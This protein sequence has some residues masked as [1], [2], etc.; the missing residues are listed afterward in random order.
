MS[1]PAQAVQQLCRKQLIH[2]PLV[3]VQQPLLVQARVLRVQHLEQAVQVPVLEPALPQQRVARHLI[4][5]LKLTQQFHMLS[6]KQFHLNQAR[7]NTRLNMKFITKTLT[8]RLIM[9]P[10]VTF[11]N[12]PCLNKKLNLR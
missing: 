10:T 6:R 5:H 12:H 11:L 7:Q 8:L 4:F 2:I 1:F 3:Q 9:I